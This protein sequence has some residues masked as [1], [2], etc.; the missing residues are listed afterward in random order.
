MIYDIE[1]GL[2]RILDVEATS[3]YESLFIREQ[4]PP[5]IIIY[6]TPTSEKSWIYEAYQRSRKNDV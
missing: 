4:N 1:E 5:V 2:S 6:S 3:W